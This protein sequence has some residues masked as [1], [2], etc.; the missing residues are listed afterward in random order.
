M[1]VAPALLAR[2]LPTVRQR[3]TTRDTILYALA[4]GAGQGDEAWDSSQLKLLYEPRLLVVPTLCSVLGDPGFW[5]QEPDTGLTWQQLVHGEESVRWVRPLPA[6]GELIAEHRVC[7]VED[8]GIERGAMFVVERTLTD[9]TSGEVFC[10]ARTTVIA[11]ADGGFSPAADPV[12]TWG[13]AAEQPLSPLPA[14]TADHCFERVVLTHQSLLYRQLADPN[15]LHADPEAAQLAGF[16]RPILH[17]MCSFGILGLMIVTRFCGLQPARLHAMRA[18]FSAPVFPGET[19]RCEF[20]R[21]GSVLRFRAS[22]PTRQ[23][24]VLNQ[25]WAEVDESD[26]PAVDEPS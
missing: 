12:K 21:E 2:P 5:M 3:W 1:I 8:R 4:I 22:V 23:A 9:A 24:I 10:R 11:R 14:R 25:G 17:G 15:P 26:A 18:R 7:R 19:L 6:Q 20:W 13:E 16:P